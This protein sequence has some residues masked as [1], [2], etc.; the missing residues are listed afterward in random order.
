MRDWTNCNDGAC[1]DCVL[2]R[3]IE[4]APVHGVPMVFIFCD[5]RQRVLEH[6]RKEYAETAVKCL[7]VGRVCAAQIRKGG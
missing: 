7:P 2:C 1:Q 3:I 4:A 6:T 5:Y